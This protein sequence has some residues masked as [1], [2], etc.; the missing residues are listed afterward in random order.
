MDK[1]Q[2]PPTIGSAGSSTGTMTPAPPVAVDRDRELPPLPPPPPV[3]TALPEESADELPEAYEPI[4][5]GELLDDVAEP[6]DAATPG[7]AEPRR[8]DTPS[9]SR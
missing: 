4:D 3:G 8:P 6:T 9:R 7:N 1:E 2:A 5:A